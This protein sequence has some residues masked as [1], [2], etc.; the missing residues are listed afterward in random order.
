MIVEEIMSRKIHTITKESRIESAL[1][2]M[3]DNSI[4]HLPVV[5]KGKLIGII[6]DRDLRQALVPLA[7][8]G[9]EEEILYNTNNFLVKDI[10]STDIITVKPYTH[11]EDAAKIILS[12]KIGSLPVENDKNKLVGIVTESD[13]LGVFIEI[14]GILKSSSRIDLILDNNQKDFEKVS[15]II[16]KNNCRIISVGIS[17][18]RKNKNQKIYFFR[19]DTCDV[20]LLAKEI[21]KA[22]FNVVNIIA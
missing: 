20:N 1:K 9:K 14:M 19:L 3:L 12:K 7:K 17:P 16:N 6:S 8:F 5:E 4:R 18:A 15:Q 21:E 13:L 10:M 2:I 11:V 22:G